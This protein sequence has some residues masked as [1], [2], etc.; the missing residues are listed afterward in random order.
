MAAC[1]WSLCT[2]TAEQ[3]IAPAPSD[4]TPASAAGARLRRRR[5][6]TRGAWGPGT[7]TMCAPRGRPG[8][9]WRDPL[10]VGPA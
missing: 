1:R 7:E 10:D 3:W 6:G 5:A 8:A 9:E 2:P 4:A